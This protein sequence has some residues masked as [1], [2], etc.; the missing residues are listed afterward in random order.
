[1]TCCF[2]EIS[3]VANIISLVAIAVLWWMP[4]EGMA[5][6]AWNRRKDA[7]SPNV[8]AKTRP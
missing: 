2:C 3:A 6:H 1:M 5:E 4:L 7:M 8:E